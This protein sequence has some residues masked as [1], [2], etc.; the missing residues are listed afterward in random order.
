MKKIRLIAIIVTMASIIY[1]AISSSEIG[2]FMMIICLLGTTTI[3]YIDL[4][5]NERARD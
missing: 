1:A 3:L 4:G 5:N 2:A